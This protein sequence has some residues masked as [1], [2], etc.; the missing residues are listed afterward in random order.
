MV[1]NDAMFYLSIIRDLINVFQDLKSVY[2]EW[3]SH[4][5]IYVLKSQY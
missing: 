4:N 1:N 2:F 3:N 5:R